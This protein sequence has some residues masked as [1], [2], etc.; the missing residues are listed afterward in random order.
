MTPLLLSSK[1]YRFHIGDYLDLLRHHPQQ[2]APYCPRLHTGIY[3]REC[4]LAP[5]NDAWFP[6]AMSSPNSTLHAFGRVHLFLVDRTD[7]KRAPRPILRCVRWGACD[8]ST[9]ISAPT[10]ETRAPRP[11]L[12]CM[13]WDVCYYSL[14]HQQIKRRAPNQIFHSIPSDAF[15][16]YRIKQTK[17]ELQADMALYQQAQVDFDAFEAGDPKR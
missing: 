2:H 6:G 8:C 11:I 10:D 4:A 14:A 16:S 3:Y 12:H 1:I 15:T 17:S 5:A 7:Q 13:R 9:G